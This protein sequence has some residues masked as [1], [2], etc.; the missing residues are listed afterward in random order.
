ML[1]SM[2]AF[3]RARRI[4]SNK[5][6]TVEIKSVN[7]RYFDCSVKLPR[8]FSFL[9]DKVKTYIQERGSTRGKIDVYIGIDI[10]SSQGIEIALDTAYAA[11][12]IAAL[13]RLRD[14]FGLR[15]D[16]SVMTVAQNRDIFT[17]KKPEEDLEEEWEELRSVID[18]A[19]ESY[20]SMRKA[21]GEKI[22][23]DIRKKMEIIAQ[24]AKKIG[25]LS[26]LDIPDYG[27]KLEQRIKQYLGDNNI[28][29][30]EQRIL[31]ECAIFA[32]KISIDEELVRLNSHF[33]AFR[34][35]LNADGPIGR[36]L[37]FL[38]QEINRETNTIGSKANNVQIA[39][40]VVD[41]KGELE[42][43]REQIQNIE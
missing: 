10:L 2:T 32:D 42:K 13:E 6:I 41:M 25:E 24:T 31:T 30:D 3:G 38:L 36:K 35:M 23:I 34:E 9:E 12:Y 20:V 18:E 19:L 39:R 33:D 7:G 4:E 17:Q 40:L 26:A 29:I 5:D 14:D 43:I 22:S 11:G 1:K 21:E 8:M 16:I 28:Q 15:D 37:D 27:A